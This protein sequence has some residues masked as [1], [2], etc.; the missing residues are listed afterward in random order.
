MIQTKPWSMGPAPFKI[1]L[2]FTSGRGAGPS[3]P[4]GC[5]HQLGLPEEGRC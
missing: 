4:S 5:P 1:S 2:D 3:S